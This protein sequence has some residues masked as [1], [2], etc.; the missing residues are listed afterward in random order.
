M[1]KLTRRELLRLFSVALPAALLGFSGR[2]YF[3][4]ELVCI[5]V[6]NMNG[7]IPEPLL[8]NYDMIPLRSKKESYFQ[9]G[10][11]ELILCQTKIRLLDVFE[12]F[13][14]FSRQDFEHM[15][16]S[17]SINF[18]RRVI[19]GSN[20]ITHLSEYLKLHAKSL[21]KPNA[22]LAVILILNDYTKYWCYSL[23]DLCRNSDIEELVIIKN[24]ARAPYLC[25]HPSQQ[26]GFKKPPPYSAG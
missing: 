13:W 26:K 7:D 20:E 2:D 10:L 25:S 23:V 21:Q 5:H 18:Q 4:D 14:P 3:D 11:P 6:Y 9:I 22:T 24:P 8:A 1:F 17:I 16:R 15:Q 12:Y 19:L